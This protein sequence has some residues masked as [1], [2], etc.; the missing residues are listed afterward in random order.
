M[1][2]VA[3]TITKFL[4]LKEME[5]IYTLLT[6]ILSGGSATFTPVIEAD[7]AAA[8]CREFSS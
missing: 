2:G 6:T 7:L 4:P 1:V 8:E 3:P 5:V